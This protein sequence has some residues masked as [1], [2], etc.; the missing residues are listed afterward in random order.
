MTEPK[1]AAQLLHHHHRR[2]VVMDPFCGSG[3]ACLA[4]Q[5][6]GRNF[7]GCDSNAESVALTWYRCVVDRLDNP[8]RCCPPPIHM[9]ASSWRTAVALG[10]ALTGLP[11]WIETRSKRPFDWRVGL[12]ATMTRG[13][14]TF[15]DR[16]YVAALRSIDWGD[17]TNRL[18]VGDCL[19]VAGCIPAG[20]VDLLYADP[21]FMTGRDFGDF[22]DR[23]QN[24]PQP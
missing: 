13:V 19:G 22:D 5:Q 7:I 10:E 4:A 11:T 24:M 21:P 1:A 20:T 17:G 23:W 9:M 14:P 18:I 16:A 8:D 3:T 6:L 2:D 12:P 15:D